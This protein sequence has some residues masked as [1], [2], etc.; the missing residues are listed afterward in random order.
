MIEKV[1]NIKSRRKRSL[2]DGDTPTPKRG[3]PRTS[4]I[5]TRYPPG[6]YIYLIFEQYSCSLVRD[7]DDDEVAVER[8]HA[9]LTKEL[10]RDKPRKEIILS[11]SRQTFQ[12]R[13]SNVLSEAADVSVTSLLVD[14]PELCNLQVVMHIS[15]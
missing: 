5:L 10:R 9:E 15:I 8:N 6:M 13:R 3:R 2:D 12:S 7:T 4:L 11:L 14:Y 1:H